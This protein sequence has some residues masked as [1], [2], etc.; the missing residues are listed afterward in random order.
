LLGAAFGLTTDHRDFP[1]MREEFFVAYESC[2]TERTYVFDGV[3]ELLDAI[4]KK[5][6]PWGV[7]TNK[8]TRFTQPLTS[9]MDLFR[10]AGAIVSGD[11]TP[12]SKPHPAPLLEAA[13]RLGVPPAQCMYVGDDERDI[14]AGLAAGMITVAASY[15]YL[16]ANADLSAW[17]SHA[18]IKSP[19]ELLNFL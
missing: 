6:L 18:S 8:A 2:M 13:T 19:G 12:H 7:V 16:G 11:T 3:A 10:S 9:A 5:G 14:V 15:G 4:S 17:G 1:A